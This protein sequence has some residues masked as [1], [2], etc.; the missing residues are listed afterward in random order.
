MSED[1]ER[2]ASAARA[3]SVPAMPR[4]AALGL[5]LGAGAAVFGM[6]GLRA[7]AQENTI[8]F[9][10]LAPLSGPWARQGQLKQLGA[11]MA[12]DEIN[13]SGG[14]KALG[15][16]KV[17][18]VI[19]D[20]GDSA[21]KAKNAAQ[22]MVAQHPD[23]I[24][25]SGAW[26]SSFTLAVTEVTER[27]EIPWLT[28]SYSDA[29]TSR[30]FRYVFQM[31]PTADDQATK[32]LPTILDMAQRATGKKPTT[33]G[34]ISGNDASAVSF[35][36]PMRATELE[37]NGLKPVVDETYT[38]PLSDATSIVQRVR[39]ARPQFLLCITSN[40]PDT[41]LLLDKFAEY[42][43]GGDR[44]PKIGNGGA[45]GAPELG[46]VVGPQ[47]IEGLMGIVANWGGKGSE[48]IS[49]RFV[50][51]TGEPWLNQDSLMTYVDMMILREALE[52]A[53][54]ADRRKVNEVIHGFDMTDGVAKLSPGG[55]LKFDERGRRV[56][57]E[58]VIIQWQSGKPVAVYPP[59]IA[60]AEPVWPTT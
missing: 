44:L 21:E 52:R 49:K 6:G 26:L 10:L 8:K 1:R 51:R 46:K 50:E 58:L 16:R 56:G 41:K 19:F 36:R 53:G 34:L 28:L 4:R 33:V 5:G 9:A 42:R 24:G 57:A 38:P 29:I 59:A 55:R 14:I 47:V 27:A 2:A 11:E 35:M 22:R 7:Q 40:V 37:R 31:S 54:V 43:L 45:L 20:A 25:G 18:L 32:A 60:T 3:A 13:Q 17:E 12:V 30:G 39:G 23:L 15:G 48:E